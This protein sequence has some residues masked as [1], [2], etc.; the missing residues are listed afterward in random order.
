MAL[1]LAL[2]LALAVSLGAARRSVDGEECRGWRGVAVVGEAWLRRGPRSLVLCW[3]W[4][5]DILGK[6][7]SNGRDDAEG[8]ECEGEA[9]DKFKSTWRVSSGGARDV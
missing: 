4:R 1:T 7:L 5:R 6:Q 3:W 8:R 9:D 2:A